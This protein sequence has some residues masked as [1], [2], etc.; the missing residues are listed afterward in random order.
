MIVVVVTILIVVMFSDF[1]GCL[2]WDITILMVVVF[3]DFFGCLFWDLEVVTPLT[4]RL[5]FGGDLLVCHTHLTTPTTITITGHNLHLNHR[6]SS[7]FS[8]SSTTTRS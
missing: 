4:D 8:S 5:Y 2:L 7:S 1:L 3:S 6:F